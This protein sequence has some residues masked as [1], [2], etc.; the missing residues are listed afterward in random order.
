MDTGTCWCSVSP[1]SSSRSW[2]HPFKPFMRGIEVHKEK[3]QEGGE[4]EGRGRG[5]GGEREGRGRGEGGEREGRGSEDND[6]SH[7]SM[8]TAGFVVMDT[9]L[10]PTSLVIGNDMQPIIT[11]LSV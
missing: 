6:T 8:V 11:F 9:L 3:G 5:E 1:F 2:N 10:G 4:R 7:V